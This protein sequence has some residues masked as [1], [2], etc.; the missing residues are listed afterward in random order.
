MPRP[1][2]PGAG[3]ARLRQA[4]PETFGFLGFTFICGKSRRGYFLLK[5][6][7]RRDRMRAK[8]KAVKQELRRRM[9][10]PIPVQ[11]K[12]LGQIVRGWFNYHA[13]PTN[14][15]AL[16]AF[17][18]F[19]TDLWRRTLRKR[20][21]QDGMTW[22]RITHLANDWLPKPKILH[23]WPQQRFAVKHPRWEP[24]ARIWP[25]RI[26]AGGAQQ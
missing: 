23:P 3:W 8:L 16:S 14:S 20:S 12:W 22:E 2:E 5:R 11:G 24:Y 6:K 15:R 13:V 7:S 18:F 9:H 10:Q 19:V 1:T 25:V 26:C 17:R 21:Q 4:Q